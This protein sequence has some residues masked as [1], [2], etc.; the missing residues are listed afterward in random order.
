MNVI[1]RAINS[2]PS[3]DRRYTY[4]SAISIDDYID[5]RRMRSAEITGFPD[6]GIMSPMLKGCGAFAFSVDIEKDV[7]AVFA[8]FLLSDFIQSFSYASKS[9]IPAIRK[10]AE[11]QFYTY[12]FF[13]LSDVILAVHNDNVKV[14]IKRPMSPEED[15]PLI[16]DFLDAVSSAKG[17]YDED[18]VISMIFFEE[19]QRYTNGVVSLDEFVDSYYARVSIYLKE[20]GS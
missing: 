11:L 17:I 19:Y 3:H 16:R 1:K 4:Y 18:P 6:A 12:P 2:D 15:L 8:G 14:D 7:A 20:K 9:V 13:D 10:N 5:I